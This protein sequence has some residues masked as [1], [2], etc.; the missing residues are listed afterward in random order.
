[1]AGV[2]YNVQPQPP[3][4]EDTRWFSAGAVTFGVEYREVDPAALAETYGDDATAMA[5][6][7]A[8]SPE[9][10]FVDAGVSIH[11]KGTAD[12]H[13]YVRFDI[14]DGEPHYH[15]VRPSGDHNNV[16]EYDAVAHGD[17]LDFA[18]GRLRTRLA[19]MLTHAGGESVAA[20]LDPV[21]QSPVIDDVEQLARRARSGAGRS[22]SPEQG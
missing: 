13:E 14:F 20:E 18:I 22:A 11:V 16:V 9:G 6:I 7:E 17:M 12:S 3:V 15:Y 2:V 21:V 8:N 10:G 19:E 5:E 4:E 1:M